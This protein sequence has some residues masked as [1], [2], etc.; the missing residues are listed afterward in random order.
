MSK[1]VILCRCEDVTLADVQHAVASG[2]GEVEEV[3]RYTGFGTGPCQG[4]ECL[5]AVT[6]AIAAASGRAPHTLQPFTTRPPLA[7]TELKYFAGRA[8]DGDAA[9]DRGSRSPPPRAATTSPSSPPGAASTPCAA[10]TAG[11]ASTAASADIAII[12]AGVM[13]L[14]L[15]YNLAR[16]GAKRVVVLDAHHLAWGASGRNGGGV[17]QQWSTEMNIRL[18]QESM[19]L[20]AGFA[21]E[22]GINIW[23]RRGGYL[24]LA[25]SLAARARLEENVALQ[26]RCDLPTRLLDM[27][28]V[29]ALVPELETAPSSG[30]FVAACY[31]PTD[32]IVFPWPFLWG[33]ARAAARLGVV[34]QTGTPVVAIERRAPGGFTIETAGGRLTAER[35]VN[36]AGAWSP[37]VARLCGVALPDWPERHEIL[38]TEPLKPFLKPMVSV[39]ES[40]LYFSQSL[41][42]E[43]VG[44]IALPRPRD[45]QVRLG[46]RL[47]FLQRMSRALLEV[48]PGLGEVKIV[49]Q[50]AGP[51]DLS[52][53]G[54]PIVGEAPGVPGFYLCCGFVGHGFMMAPVVAR[55][56]ALHLLGKQTHPL[57][58]RWSLGRFGSGGAEGAPDEASQ[59]EEMNIG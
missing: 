33:Y 10:S 21:Q 27:H 18:M 8:A 22:M 11:A 3:K 59:R 34:I 37:E 28:E 2:F 56:Y 43:V 38:S 4:K 15:A 58:A 36:A 57:F 26:N 6:M 44:G 51:Y 20:C 17:R 40:G 16:Q 30:P 25:R 35:V 48:M 9:D 50:W 47:A 14:A 29:R 13:G 41:R 53:D 23:M 32:G 12:G 31:N 24:F 54:H 52:P 19:E 55:H 46:S 42:G 45:T 1:K 5:R 7:P 49:R 39:L